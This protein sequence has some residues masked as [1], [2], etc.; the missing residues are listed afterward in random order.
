MLLILVSACSL[1][2]I[3]MRII[4][5][6]W[7]YNPWHCKHTRSLRFFIC[8]LL[9]YLGFF[10][11][12]AIFI[13]FYVFCKVYF[14]LHNL[15]TFVDFL[16]LLLWLELLIW[17]WIIV[18]KA[19]NISP[20]LNLIGKAFSLSQLSAMST[21]G[22]FGNNSLPS[23][24]SF[25]LVLFLWECLFWIGMNFVKFLFLVKLIC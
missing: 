3:E 7:S 1:L 2:Y 19:K 18:M 4:S 13:L 24:E 14:F 25:P 16:A 11:P 23:C 6:C 20:V 8:L 12:F 5:V 21:L 15:Y 17:C 10:M 9:D 22:F